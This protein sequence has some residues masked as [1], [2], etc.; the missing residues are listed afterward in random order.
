LLGQIPGRGMGKFFG[1]LKRRHIYRV[2]VA[3]AVVAWIL[4]QLFNNLTPIMNLPEWA[5]MLVLV[6]LIGGFPIALVFAWIHQLAPAAPTSVPAVDVPDKAAKGRRFRF[7]GLARTKAPAVEPAIAT[8]PAPALPPRIS[9]A[10]LPFANMSGD[11]SQEFFSDGMTEEITVALA[12]VPDLRVVG[13]TSAFQFKGQ[14]QDLRAIG[15]ALSATHIIEGSVRKGGTR[16]RITAQLIDSRNGTHLWAQNYDRDLSDVFATQDDI[17]KAIA[18][19]LDVPL[20]LNHGQTLVSN[21][22][23]D[24]DAYQEYLRAR[25]LF[26]ARSINDA[27][28][29]LESVVARDPMFAPAWGL[30]A[31]AHVLLPL[32][33]STLRRDLVDQVR[34]VVQ[35]DLAKGE[36]AAREAL[37]LDERIATGYSGLAFAQYSRSKWLEAEDLY[38]KALE[39]DPSEPDIMHFF[40]IMLAETGHIKR[41]MALREKLRALE[42]FV[43]IYNAIS[44]GTMQMGGNHD[45]AIAILE[46][47]AGGGFFRNVYLASAYAARELFDKAADTLL[48]IQ[49]NLVTRRSVEDA[50]RL[51]RT[52]MRSVA[53]QQLPVLEGELSFVYAHI[54]AADRILDFPERQLAIGYLFGSQFG[55]WLPHAEPARKTDRFKAYVRKVGLVDYWRARG[56]PDLCRPVGS[57]DFVCD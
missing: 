6:L 50:A 36:R 40:S 41:A 34:R 42:P 49:G 30:L 26:R 9:I 19:A 8:H 17:A 54:G 13:R 48:L 46:L 32:Y 15:Q 45:D 57:D 47:D 7:F 11:A 12:K 43:P 16:V 39:C 2:A 51:I 20:G 23:K 14:N 37:Q 55:L 1:E 31:N 10:V 21:R 53:P 4:L 27:I 33:T 22:T 24:L 3:Y 52:P 5:G 44:A 18:G 38:K 35:S 28:V 29:V 56:W 25:A